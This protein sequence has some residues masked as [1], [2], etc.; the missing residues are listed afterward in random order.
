ATDS[1][2]SPP[3][4]L[5][6]E[7]PYDIVVGLA[8]HER[9]PTR[10][11]QP[12][13]FGERWVQLEARERI[14]HLLTEFDPDD[15]AAAVAERLQFVSDFLR[16]VDAVGTHENEISGVSQGVFQ[17]LPQG[18][19]DREIPDVEEGFV[20]F[21]QPLERG[22]EARSISL[23]IRPRTLLARPDVGYEE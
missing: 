10:L 7:S 18:L 3:L 6:G 8:V 16:V 9:R 22:E 13:Q 12:E 1:L 5:L 23:P 21:R 11:R 15:P 4:E 17:L 2:R 14:G 19:P 20:R